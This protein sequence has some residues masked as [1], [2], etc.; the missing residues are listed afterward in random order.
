M[1]ESERISASATLDG[2]GRLDLRTLTRRC[3]QRPPNYMISHSLWG[4]R[5]G[6]ARPAVLSDRK[7]TWPL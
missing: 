1:K 7:A 4:L 6:R 2:I 5:S 3:R